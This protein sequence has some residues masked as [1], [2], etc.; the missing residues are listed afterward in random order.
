MWGLSAR[1][2]ATAR[3]V[4]EQCGEEHVVPWPETIRQMV[5]LLQEQEQEQ[6]LGQGQG[7]GQKQNQG[8]A[9]LLRSAARE[10]T[11]LG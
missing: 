2:R 3:H 4:D 5:L 1:A 8:R 6:G 9:Q 7:Q 11:R 10:E